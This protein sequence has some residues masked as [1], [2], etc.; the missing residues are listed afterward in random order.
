MDSRSSVVDR[1]PGESRPAFSAFVRYRDAAERRL[2]AKVSEI[3]QFV[4][5][6]RIAGQLR[7]DKRPSSCRRNQPQA[8]EAAAPNAAQRLRAACDAN[9]RTI[10]IV[11]RLQDNCRAS[12][13]AAHS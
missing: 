1:L 10:G 13:E 3:V 2:L 11:P 7:V 9:I 6:A 4:V 8:Q 12:T 5:G